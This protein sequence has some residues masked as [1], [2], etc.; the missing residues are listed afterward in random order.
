MMGGISCCSWWLRSTAGLE[1][2]AEVASSSLCS[3]SRSRR[4]AL[5]SEATSCAKCGPSCCRPA[6]AGGRGGWGRLCSA[7]SA[8]PRGSAGA[9]GPLGGAASTA[10]ETR[11][12]GS[13]ARLAM[14]ARWMAA[15]C[16]AI[17]CSCASLAPAA[18]CFWSCFCCSCCCCCCCTGCCSGCCAGCCSGCCAGCPSCSMGCAPSADGDGRWRAAP[19]GG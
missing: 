17:C 19:A 7:G 16:I 5:V 9:Q 18:C 11:P 14:T 3:N 1:A 10:G 6:G 12:P 13:V 15:R 4:L 8:V 2:T